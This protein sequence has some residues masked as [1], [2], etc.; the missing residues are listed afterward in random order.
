MSTYLDKLKQNYTTTTF[1]RKYEYI[2]HNVAPLL[3]MITSTTTVLE[4]GPGM[5]ECVKYLNNHGVGLI[6]VVDNDHGVLEY[7]KKTFWI[8][9]AV[10]TDDITKAHRQ[11]DRYDAIILIQVL[12]HISPQQYAPLLQSLYKMLK[13]RGKII[14]VVPNANNPL[15]IVE[16]YGDLQ[17][18]IAFTTRSLLD[19]VEDAQLTQLN[20]EVRGFR[21]PPYS[22]INIIRIF[23]QKIVHLFLLGLLI[24]NGG[25]Y[26][27]T[28]TPNI[29][30]VL[31]KKD[32]LAG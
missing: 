28:L 20:V 31:S 8:R 17:H 22:L 3:D 16:R 2:R 23:F 30:L 5:G 25:T 1:Q 13:P 6:D 15:S 4:I 27:S 12:E 14:I 11:L 18:T 24:G 9:K 21:I 32:P 7:I 29:M 26:F 10:Y 19:V